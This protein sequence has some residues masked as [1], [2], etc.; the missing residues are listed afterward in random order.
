MP[1]WIALIISIAISI[2]GQLLAPK[3]EGPKPET[4]PQL[5]A[6]DETRP[7]RAFWG[8]VLI[9]DPQLFWWGDY[10]VRPITKK[11]FTGIWFKKI[12]TGY[13]YFLGMAIGLGWG[14]NSNVGGVVDPT[15]L[16]ILEIQVNQKTLWSGTAHG[17][18]T[19]TI[20][21]PG[22]FGG[23][24]D[25]S[26]GG[27][28]AL[29]EV[30]TG[31]TAGEL[32]NQQVPSDYL[33][34]QIDLVPA[35][36]GLCYLIWRGPSAG[37]GYYGNSASLQPLAVRARH[38]P[39]IIPVTSGAQA[40]NPYKVVGTD[41][42]PVDVLA[43]VLLD[44]RWG[45]QGMILND[46]DLTSWRAA[47]QTVH[48]EGNSFAY[49][50][51]DVTPFED[52]VNIILRQIDGVIYYDI[53]T[54]KIV[55]KLARN[56]YDVGD[57]PVFDNDTFIEITSLTRGAWDETVNDLN[58]TYTNK[59]DNFKSGTITDSDLANFMIQQSNHVAANVNYPGCSNETLA[60]K[61]GRRDMRAMTLPLLRFEATAD[62]QVAG[63]Y[64][65]DVF[66][67]SW[68]EQGIESVVMRVT[69]VQV[70]TLK[71]GTVIL[72]C[73]EDKFASA[74]AVFNNNPSSWIDP[75][76]DPAPVTDGNIEELPYYFAK[77][78]LTRIYAYAKRPSGGSNAFEWTVDDL[79]VQ[80]DAQFTPTGV[81][82]ADMAADEMLSDIEVDDLFDFETH[83]ILLI[84][85]DPHLGTR[86]FKIDNEIMALGTVS[87][88]EVNNNMSS[89]STYRGLL[90]TVPEAHSA[91]A[92]VWFLNAHMELDETTY[93]HT[94][95]IT[96]QFLPFG[97]RGKVDTA[98]ADTYSLTLAKRAELP[99]VPGHIQ[100][101]DT[102]SVTP[103][104]LS[105]EFNASSIDAKW[106][107]IGSEST[108][109][110]ASG[111]LTMS[112]PSQSGDKVN[113]FVQAI[114][115]GDW[116]MEM[117]LD[118]QAPFTSFNSS[119]LL[120][121]GDVIGSPST[122][123]LVTFQDAH[124]S[125]ADGDHCS[126]VS[127]W[128]NRFTFNTDLLTAAT[129]LGNANNPIW[130]RITKTGTNYKFEYSFNGSSWTNQG[131]V[132]SGSFGFTPAYIGIYV[133]NAISGVTALSNFDYFRLPS[134]ASG[135]VA[136]SWARR[137]RLT[138]T[139]VRF[140]SDSDETPES[141]QTTNVRIYNDDTSTLLRTYPSLAGTSQN[142]TAAQEITDN[143]ALATN[144]RIEVD[145]EAAAGVSRHKQ[146][147]LIN[148]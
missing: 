16:E 107:K 8:E 141:G 33:K 57:L 89:L 40:D 78:G 6:V 43:Q 128:T 50:W 15:D 124:F 66:V 116:V 68:P 61:L 122:A 72:Q 5:P 29:I 83:D 131:T 63:L 98:D 121:T 36:R 26:T 142:Y 133:N 22:F 103:S 49:Q 136:I 82:H 37:Y 130:Q 111:S 70:G 30:S 81:L 114:P 127:K 45:L 144:L 77:D 85:D 117:K 55:L 145:S 41:A 104:S 94:A 138:E 109:S 88:D 137:N 64:P 84:T 132:G 12:T 135:Q 25:S 71:E 17:G 74:S 31:A 53:A 99:I 120:I 24:G 148:R 105:D 96:S 39:N 125:P 13:K 54:A 108:D 79:T 129:G 91:G 80:T 92:T 93:P 38:T 69:S 27:V 113:M 65:G 139:D 35:W 34:T 10:K 51:K 87:V 101:T 3:Q 112:L 2:A 60:R 23:N 119:G 11:I 123:G 44:E 134:T 62:R 42:N 118:N 21:N 67:F 95:A 7:I 58:V 47:E 9:A 46:L 4:G 20:D 75:I 110:E 146:V 19:I 106:A 97:P 14:L 86:L 56:D 90:D 100:T 1:F 59:A 28:K 18:S 48:T 52:M 102:S 76:T 140:Q 115:A 143:G 32:F 126:F 73:T 147:R